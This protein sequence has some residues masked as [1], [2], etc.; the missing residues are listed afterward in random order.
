[1]RNLSMIKSIAV[2]DLDGTI[3]AGDVSRFVIQTSPIIQKCRF[4]FYRLAGGRD[5]LRRQIAKYVEVKDSTILNSKII[6]YIENRVNFEV[7]EIANTLR[8]DHILILNSG[9]PQSLVKEI[10]N[11]LKFDYAFGSKSDHLNYGNSKYSHLL[12]HP[13]LNGKNR[14]FAISD[15]AEDILWMRNFQVSLQVKGHQIINAGTN[16]YTHTC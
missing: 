1:M 10:A 9:S 3:L 14:C 13:N 12:E 8:R 4:L 5:A 2:F 11:H 7:L 15:N 16:N 6:S